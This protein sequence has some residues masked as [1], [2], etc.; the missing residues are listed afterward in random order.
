MV[1]GI[2]F[3]TTSVISGFL[4]AWGG[5]FYTLVFAMALTV[6][7]FL[8]LLVVRVDEP[9]AAPAARRARRAA[10][11]GHRRHH[12]GHPAAVPGLFA[13]ILFATFNNFL[14]GV[15]MALLDAYGLSLV[16]GAD[17]GPA[18]RRSCR[19]AFILSGIIDLPD[20]AWAPTR[21]A[22]CCWST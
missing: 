11:G 3:L 6:L 18:V 16:D 21:C 14:G 1:T 10:P 20:R 12:P 13:L 15:F 17:L 8:H 4:V 5:M 22:P 9:R 7:A 2:G 19:R